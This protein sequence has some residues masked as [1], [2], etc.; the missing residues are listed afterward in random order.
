MKMSKAWKVYSPKLDK[1]YRHKNMQGLIWERKSAAKRCRTRFLNEYNLPR[2]AL[3]I[4]EYDLVE[5]RRYKH[6][7]MDDL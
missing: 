4:I 6:D 5:S 1:F 7:Q 3:E 2:D